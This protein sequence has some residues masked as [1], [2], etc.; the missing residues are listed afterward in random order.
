MKIPRAKD[1]ELRPFN[2][3]KCDNKNCKEDAVIFLGWS[4]K[5]F[6]HAKQATENEECS[7]RA[8]DQK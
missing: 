7:T 6:E 4:Q 3:G 5:C 1:A 2:D 8:K